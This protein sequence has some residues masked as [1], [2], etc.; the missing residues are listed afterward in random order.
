MEWIKAILPLIGVAIGW[1]LSESGKILNDKRQDKR[2]LKK[3]LFFLLE[4]RYHFARELSTELDLDKYFNILKIKM[5]DKFG[6]D[7]N[8]PELN[9]GLNTFK[10]FLEQ[11][12]SKNNVQDDKFE[13]LEENIDKILI[14]LAEIFPILAYELNGQH[15][16]KERLNKVNNYFSE[17]QSLTDE[18]PFDLKQWVNP[19]L[20]KDLLDDLDESIKRIAIQIDK[21][22][23]KES[24][25]KIEKMVFE[26]DD[27]DMNKLID[28]YLEK[29][30]ENIPKENQPPSQAHTP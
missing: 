2:K 7:K 18:L 17:L 26:D 25:E 5:A 9:L 3:L 23:L 11:L 20:T 8:D 29:I 16:I 14:E 24:N 27:E 1:L 28:E 12:I 6:I 10:P 13:Y 21:Q 19:K 30:I 4:L 15:N 22:T